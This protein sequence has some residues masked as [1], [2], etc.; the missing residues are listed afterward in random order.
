MLRLSTVLV[1]ALLFTDAL[2]GQT[3]VTGKLVQEENEAPLPYATVVVHNSDDSSMVAN[4]LT[5][6][7]GSFSFEIGPGS[8]YAVMQYI[9][10]EDGM[11]SDIEIKNG[12][13]KLELGI[14]PLQSEAVALDEV[15]IVAERS[16]MELKLDRRVFNVGKDLANQGNSAA[17]ILDKVPS[18]TVDPEGNVS[19]R[20]SQ[21]VQILVDGKPSGLISAGDTEALLRMQGDIIES[22]EVITNPSAR[23]EAEGEAG[24]INIILKKN[25]E[26]GVNGSFSATAG[27]P[28]NYG[29]SYSLNYRKKDFN[30]FSNFGIDYRKTPG[31]GFNEQRFFNEDGDLTEYYTID[32]DQERGGL[33]GYMQVGTDWIIDEQNTLTGSV[34]YRT[35]EDKNDAVITYSDYDENENLVNTTR[36]DV[37]ET[38]GE[39]N[40]ESS[41]FYKKTFDEKDRQLTVDAKYILDDET[42]LADYEQTNEESTGTVVQKSSNT[43]DEANALIQI[44][45]VHPI[46]EKSKVEGGARTTF[47][48]INNDFWVDELNDEGEFERLPTFDNFLQYRENIYALYTQGAHEFGKFA[49]Q[50]GL[51]A[52]Y[53]DITATLVKSDTS[54]IQEYLSFFPSAAASYKVSEKDQFQISYSRRLSR[55]RF[56]LLLP[57]SNYNDP[58]NNTFGNPN[59]RPEF[60]NSFEVGYLR[61]FQNG[62]LL[63]SVYYRRTTG[64]IERLTLPADDGTTIR[65]P[66][67]LGIR[68]AYGLEFNFSYD[69]TDSWNINADMNFFREI[70][71]GE[72]EDQNYSND[73]Y[74][75]SGRANT[76]VDITDN[77]KVQ[78]SYRYRAPRRTTQGKMLSS[79]SFDLAASFDVFQGKGTLTIAG[80]DLFNQRIRRMV[81]DQPDFQSE[82]E[83]QWRRSQQVTATLSYR[84]NR[85]KKPNEGGLRDEG[86]E[87]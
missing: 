84:L 77:I 60:T 66:V 63:T 83:F 87:F 18:V 12:Q 30:L 34:L 61:Y 39:H 1:F 25:Q 59:L 38:E 36:R 45:Y 44:D 82:S 9:G 28:H 6:D 13:N 62:S 5:M 68:N 20:G 7:D 21:G 31:G 51:R 81:I 48:S 74:T 54:T 86:G 4:A 11:I 46:G 19:L 16:Q 43:E 65:Y 33:G 75:F 8:Y 23:Y 55:P 41:L 42:E 22:I 70:V 73:T 29:A 26:K 50:A 72:F 78:A 58:R 37:F 56:R 64:V 79:A 85:D 76:Q 52:E 69:F 3:T 14:I 49:L 80:R 27:W 67:N 57:F 47:R 2:F 32:T 35:G 71:D 15:E 24:I 17:D 40:F 10:F 53:S